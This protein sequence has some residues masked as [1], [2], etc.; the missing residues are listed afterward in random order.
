MAQDH[1]SPLHS[2]QRF[3]CFPPA[4]HS[5]LP[6]GYPCLWG[7][8]EHVSSNVRSTNR[9]SANH[10]LNSTEAKGWL[11]YTNHCGM[12]ILGLASDCDHVMEVLGGYHFISF[13][14]YCQSWTYCNFRICLEVISFF[15][16]NLVFVQFP[17]IGE[18]HFQISPDSLLISSCY[19]WRYGWASWQHSASSK[20]CKTT[21]PT[22]SEEETHALI[23]VR[24]NVVCMT[25][26]V[27]TIIPALADFTS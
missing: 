3:R 8:V 23:G 18:E 19:T 24:M 2:V 9:I 16:L 17:S 5:I 13:L 6:S 15:Y 25:R 7:L 10:E 14:H 12:V 11:F 27:M 1:I 20:S 22:G 4:H 21:R 26:V